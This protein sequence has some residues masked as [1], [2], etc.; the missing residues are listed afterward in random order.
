MA[1]SH[2][3]RRADIETHVLPD[4]TCLLFDPDTDA[5]HVLDELGSLVWDY[6]DGALSAADITDEVAGL[7]PEAP[8]LPAAVRGLLADFAEAGL[9]ACAPRSEQPSQEPLR[10]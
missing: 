6:C 10:Q 7:L 3:V 2:P 8:H 9:L 1:G 4:G 5:G